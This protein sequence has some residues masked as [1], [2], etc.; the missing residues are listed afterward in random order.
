MVKRSAFEKSFSKMRDDILRCII[1]DDLVQAKKILE[2]V[3]V[4]ISLAQ[5]TDDERKE[6]ECR[7]MESELHIAERE[8]DSLRSVLN[9]LVI[10][11]DSPKFTENRRRDII[12]I[13]LN[14][15]IRRID[16]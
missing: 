16:L 13:G 3:K 4:Y 11:N 12:N 14:M 9:C 2:D 7:V 8:V 1:V 5:I 15:I 6:A 10:I